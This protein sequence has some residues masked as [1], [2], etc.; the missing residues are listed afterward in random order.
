MKKDIGKISAVESDDFRELLPGARTRWATHG[1]VTPA[2]AH[3][4]LSRDVRSPWCT[5]AS[6]RTILELKEELSKKGYAFVSQTDTEVIPYLIEEEM[7]SGKEFPAAFALP[8][9]LPWPLRH[10]R[11]P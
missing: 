5:T 6:S 2:N 10:P 1:G 7:K 8:G 9:T 11:V 4:H 3:P